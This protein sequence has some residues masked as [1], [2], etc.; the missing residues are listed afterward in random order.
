M[1]PASEQLKPRRVGTS[2]VGV[3]AERN[4]A[5]IGAQE[6]VSSGESRVRSSCA[7]RAVSVPSLSLSS[8]VDGSDV[9]KRR[10]QQKT[11]VESD[12][13]SA[14]PAEL[15]WPQR[16]PLARTWRSERHRP[17]TTTGA[18]INYR[19]RARSTRQRRTDDERQPPGPEETIGA[20]AGNQL[21]VAHVSVGRPEVFGK[22]TLPSSGSLLGERGRNESRSREKTTVVQRR[23]TRANDTA[24]DNGHQ[25]TGK[26]LA[27]A[28]TFAALTSRLPL[29][30]LFCC[31]SPFSQRAASDRQI[32]PITGLRTD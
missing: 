8:P 9:V 20:A 29:W 15:T 19:S 25:P 30:R 5:L 24:P 21:C 4:A 7:S 12:Q 1:F 14:S 31:L 32:R 6:Q 10:R 22:L 2:L 11:S 27:P 17:S 3:N 28:L 18:P 13:V 26:Q 23:K 16:V